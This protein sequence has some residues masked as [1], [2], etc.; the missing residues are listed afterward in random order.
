MSPTDFGLVGIAT[1]FIVFTQGLS[2]LGLSSGLIR[3]EKPTESQL[4]TVFYFG[5]VVAFM[6]SFTLFFSASIIAK[7]YGIPELKN[8][9]RSISFLFVLNSLNTVQ[10][11]LFYKNLEIKVT[12]IASVYAAIISGIIGITLA[13]AGFGVYSLVFSSYTINI[14]FTIIVWF[15]SKWRPQ[16][17]FN[18]ADLKKL[19]PFGFRV[20][21]I[22]Y[23]DQVYSKLDVFLIGKFFSPATLGYYF[24][25]LS[26]NQVIT[27]YS[28][29]SLS[30]VFFPAIRSFNY[31]IKKI[32]SFYFKTF[33]IMCFITFF[34]TGIL[35]V[36]AYDVIIILFGNKWIQSV[37]YFKI[38][39]FILLT[40]PLTIIFNG[41][42]LGTNNSTMQLKL[43][44]LKKIIGVV[45]T[46]TGLYF[47]LLA[48]LYFSVTASLLSML[49][50]LYYIN[51]VLG[52][53]FKKLILNFAV[54]LIPLCLS[55]IG[56]ELLKIYFTI[57]FQLLNLVFNGIIYSLIFLGISY[58]ISIPALPSLVSILNKTI[59]LKLKQK[60]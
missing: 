3:E 14:V 46:L 44:V 5:L 17:I 9:T 50:S 26:L 27:K 53:G 59:F 48:L 21:L 7:F 33:N 4:N 15:K 20:F 57:N 35:Y 49:I 42:F 8:I 13:Y 10:S 54:Y 52:T 37:D 56:V 41:V 51:T 11:A 12:R 60:V 1:V 47:G 6:L 36:S 2:N 45:F 25:A 38:I 31:D 40:Y 16:I 30:G 58:F 43:E 19:L 34:L 22:E 29:Q 23:L 55:I 18:L 28:A 32:E 24:R 39:A